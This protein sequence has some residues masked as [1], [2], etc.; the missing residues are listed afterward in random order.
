MRRLTKYLRPLAP[1]LAVALFV[2]LSACTGSGQGSGGDPSKI[3]QEEIKRVE[4]V[5]SA[6]AVVQRLRPNWLRK[7]GPSSISNPGTIYVYVEGNR[8]GS[9]ES[10]RQIDPINVREMEFLTDDR[11]TMRFGTGH[12]NGVILVRLKGSG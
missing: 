11:A 7:R 3:T 9:P 2:A 4:Q 1:F 8:Y 6:Y 12:D 5:S 10:L